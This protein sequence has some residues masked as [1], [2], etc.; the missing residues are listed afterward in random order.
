VVD[1]AGLNLAHDKKNTINIQ[2]KTKC[3]EDDATR[4]NRCGRG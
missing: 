3:P 1:T 4:E 2:Q